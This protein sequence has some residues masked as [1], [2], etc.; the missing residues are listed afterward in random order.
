MDLVLH[1]DYMLACF[2]I[3]FLFVTLPLWGVL[4]QLL[5]LM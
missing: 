3:S 2:D 4:R 1:Q 5:E